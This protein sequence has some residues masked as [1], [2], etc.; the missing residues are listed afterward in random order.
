MQKMCIQNKEECE[1]KAGEPV[2]E[3]PDYWKIFQEIG[4][5][6]KEYI[7]EIREV[8]ELIG[9]IF[10]IYYSVPVSEDGSIIDDP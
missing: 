3:D 5:W 10:N 9:N 6:R 4:L 1:V 8:S 7:S 2:A